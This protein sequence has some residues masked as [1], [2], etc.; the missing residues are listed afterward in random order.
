MPRLEYTGK[1]E[2]GNMQVCVKQRM[3]MWNCIQIIFGFT[4]SVFFII[5]STL[6]QHQKKQEFVQNIVCNLIPQRM[7]WLYINNQSC[8][9]NLNVIFN[10]V[11]LLVLCKQLSG[12]PVS[13]IKSLASLF[14]LQHDL[15]RVFKNVF[16]VLKQPDVI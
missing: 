11:Y 2:M 13:S 5:H 8:N 3:I 1:I 6:N 16:S 15:V 9:I 4:L 7:I 14:C 10:V 12:P